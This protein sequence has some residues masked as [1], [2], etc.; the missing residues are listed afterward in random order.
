MNVVVIGTGYVGLNTAVALAYCGHT[1]YGVDV[2][3]SKVDLLNKG[4]PT[5][6]EEGLP[7]LLPTLTESLKLSF[8]TEY[9]HIPYSD[10]VFITVGTPSNPDGSAN[11]S[12]I[13]SVV[14]SIIAELKLHTPK[15]NLTIVIKSTVPFG[16]NSKIERLIRSSLSSDANEKLSFASNPEFLR[17]GTALFD[18][19]FPDRIVI[20]TSDDASIFL[21]ALY[22]PILF[23]AF[24]PLSFISNE[25]IP[26]SLPKLLITDQISAEMIKYASNCFLALKISFANELSGLAQLLGANMQDISAGMGMDKRIAPYFLNSGLGWGGSCFPKDTLALLSIGKDYNYGLPIIQASVDVNNNQISKLIF[27]IQSKLHTLH[28]KRIAIFGI[29]FKPNTDDVRN[30]LAIPLATKLSKLGADV[31]LTDPQ[32]LENAKSLYKDSNFTFATTPEEAALDADAI[33]VATEWKEYRD[34]DW[35][36][37]ACLMRSEDSRFLFDGRN[38]L[39]SSHYKELFDY[40][41]I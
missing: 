30:S 1:V 16:V 5:I 31:V 22:E 35:T 40:S 41:Y 23:R 24:K 27:N 14:D 33:I 17:E 11:L 37:I 4:I 15:Q 9:S 10:V 21:N 13:Y 39:Y 29:T 2:D 3:K 26:E 28:G 6:F 32:G 25:R 36:R 34:L 12:Y 19:F 7:E 18:T 8:S 38:I 20:G